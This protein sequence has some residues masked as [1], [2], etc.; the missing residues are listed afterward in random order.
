[1]RPWSS[2]F[3]R[4]TSSRLPSAQDSNIVTTNHSSPPLTPA[5]DGRETEAVTRQ[6]GL[7]ENIDDGTLSSDQV[8]AVEADPAP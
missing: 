8:A 4:Q 5:Q 2:P 1:M 6:L 3:K 7:A